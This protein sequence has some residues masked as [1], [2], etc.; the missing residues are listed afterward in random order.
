MAK[1]LTRARRRNIVG[2]AFLM[3]FLVLFFT[4]V[5]LPVIS[6]F[7]LSL[8][9]YNLLQ[10]PKFVGM[11]NYKLLLLDDDVFLTAIK[12]TFIFA[13]IA[14]PA[15]FIAS[16]FFAAVI[17][18]LKFR[19]FFSLAFYAPSLCSAVAISSIW[20]FFF[21]PNRDGLINSILIDMG[22]TDKQIL[23][24]S[25]P[26]YIMIVI[27]IISVWMSM[28]NGF[29]VFL[30]GLQNLSAEVY[31]AARIDGMRSKLQEMVYITLPMM[32]P[33]LLFG[34]I[35][36]IVGA[37]GVYDIAV[38]VAGLPSPE[39]AGHTI[40]THLYDYAFIRLQMGYASAVAVI[41]FI[42]TFLLGRICTKVFGS[43]D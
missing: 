31:E 20:L 27:V 26:H 18:N 5:I 25:D 3:P 30:A 23:W 28:G 42:I 1:Q 38:S 12:N 10:T 16:F 36:A 22:L 21:S 19:G 13:V 9:N 40:V 11:N 33:Q 15:G 29:L 2:Y 37:F 34:S 17:T 14:G 4:F 24:T 7:V 32:K 8:T 39:Y 35:T 41:L 43:N 6:S